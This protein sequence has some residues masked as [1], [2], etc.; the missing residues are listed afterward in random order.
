MAEAVARQFRTAR[1]STAGPLEVV[2]VVALTLGV[3]RL[4]LGWDWTVLGNEPGRDKVAQNPVDWLPV[5][6]VAMAAVGWLAVRGRPVLGFIVVCVPVVVASGWR[7]AVADLLDWP[8]QAAALIFVLSVTCMPTALAGWWLRQ[9]A[10]P[11][12]LDGDLPRS[13]PEPGDDVDHTA[14]D[15][16]DD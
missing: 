13:E 15:P 5:V 8:N 16:A 9:R 12:S 1:R 6:L 7:F 11:E 10:R 14:V 3:W 4:T 2:V